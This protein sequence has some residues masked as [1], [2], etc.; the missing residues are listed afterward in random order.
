MSG[1]DIELK[2]MMNI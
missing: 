1:Q 2:S